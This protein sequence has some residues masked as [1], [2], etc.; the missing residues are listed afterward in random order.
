MAQHHATSRHIAREVSHLGAM[1][2]SIYYECVKCLDARRIAAAF[3]SPN[4]TCDTIDLARS[5]INTVLKNAAHM[6]Q[7]N[8]VKS[9]IMQSLDI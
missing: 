8:K 7:S 1:N 4:E 5:H 9:F 6:L 2:D 3:S